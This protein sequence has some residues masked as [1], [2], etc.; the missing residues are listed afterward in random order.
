MSSSNASLDEI[1][2]LRYGNMIFYQ[3]WSYLLICL[4]TFGDSMN[5][6]VFTRPVL[7]SNPCA[8]YFLAA[9]I[10]GLL[11]IPANVLTRLLQMIYPAYNPFG[12]SSAS[13]KILTFIALCAKYGLCFLNMHRT[14]CCSYR[15]N[16][17][18]FVTLASIDR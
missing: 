8:R 18:W 16:P 14:F 5:I 9:A 4:G 15:D 17:S 2:A 10:C 6:Y 1:N 13:C 7:R 12:Y 3:F 11:V